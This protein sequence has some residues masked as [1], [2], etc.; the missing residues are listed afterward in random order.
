MAFSLD[1]EIKAL[2]S[3]SAQ[4]AT[5]I[6]RGD[7]Q[8]IRATYSAMWNAMAAVAPKYPDVERKSFSVMVKDGT[9]IDLRWYTKKGSNPGSAVVYAHGGGKILGSVEGH[10]SIVA[11]YVSQSGVPFLSVEY[12]LAPE[13]PGAVCTEDTYAACVWLAEH[14]SELGVDPTRIAV[15]GDS[16]GAGIMAGVAILARDQGFSLA[17]QILIYPMLDDRTVEPDPLM[18][19]FLSWSYDNNY[20]AWYAIIGDDVGGDHVSPIVSPA[21]NKN[22]EGLAPTYLEVGELDIFRDETVQYASKLWQAGVSVELHVHPGCNHGYDA[23]P[24]QVAKRVMQ[25]RIRVIEA[26]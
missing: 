14:A 9:M 26:I 17:K 21:R 22:F 7:W 4:S 5:S 20:T 10:D 15:A 11:N 2:L 8:T 16:G 19:P 23:T 3:K 18:V 6:E 1:P 12:R 25:D 13:Y 24:I